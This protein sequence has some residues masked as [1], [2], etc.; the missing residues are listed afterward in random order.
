MEQA[1]A[2]A[3]DRA[4]TAVAHEKLLNRQLAESRRRE[5]LWQH[6]AKAA[7]LAGDDPLARH[8]LSRRMEQAKLVATLE[9]QWGAASSASCKLQRQIQGLKAKLAETKRRLAA[10]AARQRVAEARAKLHAVIPMGTGGRMPANFSRWLER[11]ELAEAES[12]ALC[13]L[14]GITERD[15]GELVEEDILVE[16]ELAALKEGLGA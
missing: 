4:V 10:L 1:V 9:E 7:V 6:R 15:H 16:R 8:A 11:L 12:E 5:E 14:T 3:L 2:T 13:E